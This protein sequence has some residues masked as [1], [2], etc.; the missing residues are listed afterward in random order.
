MPKGMLWAVKSLPGGTG[1]HVLGEAIAVG[2]A[3]GA[4]GRRE[5]AK[6]FAHEV[7]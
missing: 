4:K 1:I 3:D 6:V 7:A 5:F 2:F